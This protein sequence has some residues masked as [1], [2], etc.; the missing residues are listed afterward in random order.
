[1]IVDTPSSPSIT[2]KEHAGFATNA[3]KLLKLVFGSYGVIIS[4]LS[5][6]ALAVLNGDAFSK[7][8]GDFLINVDDLLSMF[9]DAFAYPVAMLLSGIILLG[10]VHDYA[11]DNNIDILLCILIVFLFTGFILG[12]M[13]KHPAWALVSGFVVMLSFV[14]TFVTVVNAIDYIANSMLAVPFSISSILYGSIEGIFGTDIVSIFTFSIVENGFML[15]LF[16]AFWGSFFMPSKRDGMR[17]IVASCGD[18]K[19]CKI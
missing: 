4:S 14:I 18:G 5:I 19:I 12:R 15:G 10:P 13:F 8:T 16:S 7:F 6:M 9:G 3:R 2:S 11:L 17:P 1:M